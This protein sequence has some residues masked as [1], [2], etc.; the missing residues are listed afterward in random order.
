MGVMVLTSCF[1]PT[2]L[3]NPYRELTVIN[4]YPQLAQVYLDEVPI[5]HSVTK[6]FYS[7]VSAT[8]KTELLPGK[9]A[10]FSGYK[11]V[12]QQTYYGESWETAQSNPFVFDIKDKT[13]LVEVLVDRVRNTDARWLGDSSVLFR[14]NRHGT[15]S[16]YVWD[17]TQGEACLI[18]QKTQDMAIQTWDTVSGWALF[19]AQGLYLYAKADGT[20]GI[21][22]PQ[23]V[24]LTQ[25][26]SI[27]PLIGTGELVVASQGSGNGLLWIGPADSVG[28]LIWEAPDVALAHFGTLGVF[29]WFSGVNSDSGRKIYRKKPGEAP[30]FMKNLGYWK[31][32]VVKNSIN[33]EFQ[34]ITG[35]RTKNGLTTTFLTI[36]DRDCGILLDRDQSLDTESGQFSPEGGHFDFSGVGIHWSVDLETGIITERDRFPVLGTSRTLNY[37]QDFET[38]ETS[39]DG[40]KALIYRLVDEVQ[41]VFLRDLTTGQE[42]NIS[43]Y[44]VGL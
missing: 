41:E 22:Q 44:E 33:G 26:V 24:N 3:P 30:E 14:S 20:Q 11:I 34:A 27:V 43:S 8:I 36:L 32:A 9:K 39:P 31:N 12:S 15:Q 25:S 42:I 29:S 4:P 40:T 23:G 5:N 2:P 21:F 28:G 13:R 1:T 35:F 38:G 18:G 7:N 17:N 6:A 10:L 37:V 19:W 16:Y